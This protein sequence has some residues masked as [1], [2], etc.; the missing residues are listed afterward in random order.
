MIRTPGPNSPG[1]E[2]S[3]GS[4][5]IVAG[6]VNHS[7]NAGAAGGTPAPASRRLIQE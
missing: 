4:D 1:S 5:L 3:I 6:R 2:F 7:Y